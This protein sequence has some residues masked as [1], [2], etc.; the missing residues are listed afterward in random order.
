MTTEEKQDLVR[1]FP[2]PEGAARMESGPVQF[3]DEDW[4][5][6]FMRGDDVFQ[7]V[8]VLKRSSRMCESSDSEDFLIGLQLNR[9]MDKLWK[10]ILVD[11][12]E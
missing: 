7:L 2:L 1:V 6:Y 8:S 5:G 11:D 3:G 12:E 10:C 9:T 4:P